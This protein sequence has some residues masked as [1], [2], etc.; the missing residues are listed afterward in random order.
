MAA[1]GVEVG[2]ARPSPFGIVGLY[3]YEAAGGNNL[4]Q[5]VPAAASLQFLIAAGDAL[6]DVQDGEPVAGL[7]RQDPAAQAELVAAL[8]ALCHYAIASTA[9]R[10]APS[11]R[12][13]AASASLARLELAAM[14]G[15]HADVNTHAA[16]TV[17]L[18]AARRVTAAKSGSLG[19][20]AAETGAGLATSDTALVDLIG[21]FGH[22]WAT[23]VQI[24]NDVSGVWPGGPEDTDISM[25]RLTIP[26]AIGLDAGQGAGATRFKDLVRDAASDPEAEKEARAVLWDSGAIH[27]AWALAGLHYARASRIARELQA[28]NPHS[29]LHELLT[30]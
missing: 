20:A 7:D 10:G 21:E 25:G 22:Q 8:L 28:R 6:D 12:V 19:R 16:K 9:A 14:S 23:V 13:V 15:Q 26:I 1:S 17:S 30:N 18:D 24:A 29:R 2:S 4:D 27:K 11:E 3:S 5:A